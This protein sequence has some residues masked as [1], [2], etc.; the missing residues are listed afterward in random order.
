MAKKSYS[1]GKKVLITGVSGF[2]GNE[3]AHNLADKGYKIAG[4]VR[5]TSGNKVTTNSLKGKINI[6]EGSLL[7]PMRIEFVVRDFSPDIIAHLGAITPVSYS[8]D[9]PE[10]VI[11]TNLM[12][13]IHLVQSARRNLPNLERFIFASSMET[14]GKIDDWETRHPFTEEDLQYPTS[15]YAVAK[16]GAE[17]FIKWANRIAG[18]ESE[19]GFPGV[20]FRQTNAYGRKHDT[21][22]IVETI[23]EQMLKNPDRINLGD[24]K[25]IRNFIFIDDLIDLYST[26]IESD[27]QKINGEVFN[28]GPPNGLTI[29]KLAEKIKGIMEWEGK[30]N[31]Y[32]REIRPGEIP[33]LDSTHEKAKKMLGW[34]PKVSLD[35]G[36]KRTVDYLKAK[37]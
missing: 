1:G 32:T 14:Y 4:L 26:V 5:Q 20:M 9:R 15:P 12:G 36:L 33:C 27:N 29:K 25:P 21:Y 8:L 28:T 34:E 17:Q 35:E 24:P 11:N 30:I 18:P 3:L 37:G 22:F 23:I 7:D 13:T 19:K 10:E 2:I 31:W 16:I 6:Y